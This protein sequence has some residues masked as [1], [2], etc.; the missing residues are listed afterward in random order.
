MA[1]N[2]GYFITFEGGEGAGKTTQAAILVKRLAEADRSARYTR[3][4]GG[5]PLARAIGALL[6]H[7]D[8]SIKALADAGFVSADEPADRPLPIT[9]VLLFSA[10]RAQHV[11]Y[12]R[13]WI[14]KGDIVVCDRFAD[15]TKAY[16]GAGRGVDARVIAYIEHLT[17]DG[18]QPDLTFLLDL[19]VE[20]GRFRKH[21]ILEST[22]SQAPLFSLPAEHGLTARERKRRKPA[23]APGGEWNRLDGERADL[24]ERARVGYLQLAEAEPERWVVLDATLAEEVV[25]ERIWRIVQER[26]S[27]QMLSPCDADK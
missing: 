19:P 21:R 11:I 22:L 18:L 24:H 17:T 25:A 12:I 5:T 6:L 23:A 1:V 10:A 7:P 16:Q 15:A 20:E 14:E 3:E 27:A 8:A 13:D 2:R 9:E 4:P 26:L